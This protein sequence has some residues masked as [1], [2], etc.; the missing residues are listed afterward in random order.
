MPPS[1]PMSP[2]QEPLERWRRAGLIDAPTAA[3]IERWEAERGPPAERLGAPV[4][5][6]LA[7]G[8]VL[9]A[10]G[11]LL[12][13]SAQWDTLAPF[14]R[15]ALLLTAVA[16][17]HGLAAA[18]APRF[19]T[20]AVALHGVG[21]V[22]LGGGIFLAGQIFH[23]EAHW[24]AGLLLWAAGAAVGWILLGQWPQLALL[25][26]LLP[27][28]LSSEW[29][30][31]CD[32]V[33]QDLPGGWPAAQTVLAAGL[34]LLSL[35]LFTA[36]GPGPIAGNRRVLL[37]IGGLALLPCAFAW[38]VI[39]TAMDVDPGT[40]PPALAIPGWAVALG[41]PLVLGWLLRRRSVW[42]L[43]V[44]L[45]W[46]LVDLAVRNNGITPLSH[47][48]W[49]LGSVLLVVWGVAEARP[50]RINMGA[51]LTALTVIGFYFSEVMDRLGRS[52]SLIGLGVLFLAG[53]WGL[54]RLR[55]RLVATARQP[56][57]P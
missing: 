11:I 22:A 29:L 35:S 43:G 32:A 25:V 30:R 23:L 31:A 5:L 57:A 3:A 10:A 17:L 9:L 14:A 46:M 6:A 2:W 48:W 27:A 15:F 12:F 41:G 44:A 4:R 19:R 51:A 50:E 45:A 53:G 49:L 33:L 47:G 56:A 7:L 8:A 42:P 24:P 16:G 28:W 40:L 37:W 38:G 39:A 36:P 1:F 54:E 26:L 34:L 13:V 18:L 55:R 52:A 20:M 21:T